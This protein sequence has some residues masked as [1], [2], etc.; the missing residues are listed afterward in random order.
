MTWAYDITK[1]ARICFHE[2]GHVVRDVSAAF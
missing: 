2:H 1:V